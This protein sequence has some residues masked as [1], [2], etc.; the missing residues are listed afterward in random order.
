MMIEIIFGAVLGVVLMILF[1]LLFFHRKIVALHEKIN[2]LQFDLRSK[3]VLHGKH[4][5]QFVPFM[6]NFEKI[7]KKEN[8]I[9]IGMPIDG[10]SFD[11]DAVKFIEIKT[12]SAQLSKKQRHIKELINEK[13]VEWHELKFDGRAG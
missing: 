9:F 8:F 10:I 3:S 5:E 12:G 6:P 13:K 11:E 1:Y 2:E 7:A 4:W